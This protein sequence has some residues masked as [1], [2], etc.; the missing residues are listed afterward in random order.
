MRFSGSGIQMVVLVLLSLWLGEQAQNKG[1][2]SSPWG[3]L[4]GVFFGVFASIYH[5]IKSVSKY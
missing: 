3:Q 4:V 2:I 1:W 5:L